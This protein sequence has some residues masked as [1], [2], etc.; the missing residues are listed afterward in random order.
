MLWAMLATR[1]RR[2][3]VLAVKL[4]DKLAGQRALVLHG[5]L[6]A[7]LGQLGENGVGIAIGHGCGLDERKGVLF[8]CARGAESG[9]GWKG[10]Q[11]EAAR[12]VC[13]WG[14][15]TCGGTR[16]DGL[17]LLCGL[18]GGGSSSGLDCGAPRF[19][20]RRDTAGRRLA[21]ALKLDALALALQRLVLVGELLLDGVRDARGVEA[22][23]HLDE[24]RALERGW[25]T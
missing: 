4:L 20:G 23:N 22:A 12:G 14:G 21:N 1:G 24:R 11:A 5:H 15:A 9:V 6:K 16:T 7:S 19:A 10:G 18:L 8:G 17:L 2:T 13:V 3:L 25:G